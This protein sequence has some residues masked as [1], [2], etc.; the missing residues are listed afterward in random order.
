MILVTAEKPPRRLM[1]GNLYKDIE[2]HLAVLGDNQLLD[3]V[4]L[5]DRTSGKPLARFERNGTKWELK[6]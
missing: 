5:V 2:E 1:Q 6:P 3:V 4:A